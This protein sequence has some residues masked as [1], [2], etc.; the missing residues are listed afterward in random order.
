MN[1]ETREERI[2][3]ITRE[4]RTGKYETKE[5]FSRACFRLLIRLRNDKN[6]RD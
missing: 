5:K 1:G 3:R 2:V 4:V 6:P